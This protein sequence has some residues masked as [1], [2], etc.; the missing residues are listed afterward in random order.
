MQIDG[1][2]HRKSTGQKDYDLAKKVA[3]D[4]ER[5]ARES[6]A[7]YQKM[8]TWAE[9]VQRY[10]DGE[11][12]NK[13]GAEWRDPNLLAFSV[14]TWGK[15][16]LD[17]IRRSDC[18]TLLGAR[19]AMGGAPGTV[20]LECIR[21]KFL[22]QLAIYDKLLRDNPWGSGKRAVKLPM[23]KPRT[24]VL[25]A[26]EE[27]LLRQGL[28]P[29][30]QRML[31]VVLG[32]GL[33]RSELTALCPR[34]LVKD[35]ALARG[36]DFIHI[37]AAIAKNGKERF[38]PVRLEVLAAL[39]QQLA[40][41]EWESRPGALF[42]PYHFATPSERIREAARAV[43]IKP[44]ITLHDLRRTFGTRCAEAGIPPVH[45][46]DIMGHSDLK[47]TMSFY[48]HVGDDSLRETLLGLKMGAAPVPTPPVPTD[49]KEVTE[50]EMVGV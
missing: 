3:H 43:G 25:R 20:W 19:L 15:R 16:K 4:F 42:W 23:A 30:W 12:K 24:R 46:K 37:P 48:V 36:T 38:V 49:T 32:T 18:E 21:V 45:L 33:R 9:W 41:G 35:R 7:G 27:V 40:E 13:K 28:A 44:A 26:A 5:N 1:R 10:L 8:P 22:F 14:K 50:G 6:D 11:A 2:L 29:E 31:T 47:T 17:S 39:K 34:L